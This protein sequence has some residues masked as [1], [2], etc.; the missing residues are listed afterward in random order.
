MRVTLFDYG[1][2]NLHS[3][4]KALTTAPDVEVRVQE[5]PLR[6]L[7]T[8]VLVLPGV[9][10]FGAAAARL[11]PGREAMRRA[12]DAG[13]P[14]LG[15][16]LGMQL[17]FEGS[18]EGAGEGLGYFQGRVTRLAAR[19][20]PQIGWNDVEEDGALASAKLASVYYAHSYVCRAVEPRD[21]VGWTTHEGDRFPAS[22]RRGKVL[23]VQFHPE[24]SS[25]V[26]VRFVQ[27]FL[28]EVAP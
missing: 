25:R 7:D 28:Q 23:G 3:L 13:L 15:I 26:G 22:V 24:K 18:D 12:L 8:D 2:G 14:C 9:G 4:A 10:A 21:V 20:V 6:A 19:H 5:D 11:A 17:L 27:A 16:C 1:A